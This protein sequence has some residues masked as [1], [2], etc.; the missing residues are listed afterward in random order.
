MWQPSRSLLTTTMCA[1]VG[2]ETTASSAWCLSPTFFPRRQPPSAVMSTLACASLIRSDRDSAEKPPKMTV[3]AA[4]SLAHA[5][6]EIGSS[7]II[8]R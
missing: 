7:G 4:P 3:C 8:G 2:V 6:M 5:S 1:I